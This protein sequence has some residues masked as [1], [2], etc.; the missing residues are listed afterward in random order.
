[1]KNSIVRDFVVKPARFEEGATDVVEFGKRLDV[2]PR[3]PVTDKRKP[4]TSLFVL[5]G[6]NVQPKSVCSV[7]ATPRTCLSCRRLAQEIFAKMTTRCIKQREGNGCVASEN[8]DRQDP[9]VSV[10]VAS[11]KRWFSQ[12]NSFKTDKTDKTDTTPRRTTVRSIL[13]RTSRPP[14]TAAWRSCSQAKNADFP[15]QFTQDRQDRKT[16]TL[17]AAADMGRA[18]PMDRN[19]EHSSQKVQLSATEGCC[20]LGQ[21][22]P[23]ADPD[24]VLARRG[25]GG[26]AQPF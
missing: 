3:L 24:G 14:K 18:E 11:K 4:P 12:G 22:R 23:P 13:I 9:H 10:L 17:F 7:N 25:A 15:G 19:P 21:P 2:E 5:R 20:Q 8:Q 16:A 1:V 26:D 6:H